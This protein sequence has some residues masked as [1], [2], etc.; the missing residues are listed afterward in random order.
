[1]NR[2]SQIITAQFLFFESLSSITLEV[3][4][5]I[6]QSVYIFKATVPAGIRKKWYQVRRQTTS[7]SIN[8]ITNMIYGH[9]VVLKPSHWAFNMVSICNANQCQSHL[10]KLFPSKISLTLVGFSWLQAT[11]VT[12]GTTVGL[13]HS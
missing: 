11:R 2:S 1:M 10:T 4:F 5:E 3:E 13:H 7:I 8:N 12:T 6:E 9:E